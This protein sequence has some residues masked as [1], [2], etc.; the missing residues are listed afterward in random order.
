MKNL[1]GCLIL[2]SIIS[3][4]NNTELP[5]Y[6]QSHFASLN[7]RLK[8]YSENNAP[9]YSFTYDS[10]HLTANA[11]Y[12]PSGL[13]TYRYQYNPEGLPDTIFATTPLYSYYMIPNYSDTMINEIREYYKGILEYRF[14]FD[15][16]NYGNIVRVTRVNKYDE[17][18]AVSTF[19]W[20]EN[21]IK[22]YVISYQYLIP[23]ITYIY[24]YEYDKYTN[25][26]IN[27]FGKLNFNLIDFMPISKNNWTHMT[28]YNLDY[29]S[30]KL[31]IDNVFSYASE[32]P[33]VKEARTISYDGTSK[34]IYAEYS[35]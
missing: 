25:P 29:P 35:Y 26:Y 15:Y 28:G 8:E 11:V 27:V 10:N 20:V 19:V 9:V 13:N 30:N 22:E 4:S 18:L 24:D 1:A 34:D 32:F 7:F 23:P 17:V 12:D 16:D 2:L 14:I 3:C 21:N 6:R 33:F 31:T 5:D